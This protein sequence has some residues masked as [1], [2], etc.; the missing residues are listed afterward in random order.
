[1]AFV[2]SMFGLF[3]FA[4]IAAF[5]PTLGYLIFFRFIDGIFSSVGPT[6]GMATISDMYTPAERGVPMA[7]SRVFFGQV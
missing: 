5:P 7:V 4:L 2:S 1:M 6:L 3:V